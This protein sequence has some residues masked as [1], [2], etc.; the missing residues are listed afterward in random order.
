MRYYFSVR[1]PSECSCFTGSKHFIV[2]LGEFL[3]K[4]IYLGCT[5]L[6]TVLV[7]Q[8]WFCHCLG[9]DYPRIANRQK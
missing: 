1:I 8:N 7:V 9:A 4:K 6:E 3:F 2:A 5:T